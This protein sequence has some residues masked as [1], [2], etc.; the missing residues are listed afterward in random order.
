[1]Y[2]ERGWWERGRKEEEKKKIKMYMEFNAL[3]FQAS[4]MI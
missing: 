3:H 1:M 4:L 2:K